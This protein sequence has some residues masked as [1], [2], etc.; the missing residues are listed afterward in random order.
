MT[1][2]AFRGSD[3]SSAPRPVRGGGFNQKHPRAA[4]AFRA[5]DVSAASAPWVLRDGSVRLVLS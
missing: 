4:S 5:R 3:S 1:L 2:L